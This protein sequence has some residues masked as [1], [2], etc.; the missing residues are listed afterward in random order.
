MTS[1]P[2]A[3]G[4]VC[5]GLVKA[6][7]GVTVLKAVDFA[8]RPGT[9]VGLIGENGAGKS[10]LSSLI[11]GVITPDAGTMTL[12]G[13]PYVP[14][15]PADALAQGVALI[16]QEVRLLPDLSVA[17]NI[18]LGRLP[19][20]NGRIDRQRMNDEAA[21]ALASLGVDI[22][23]RRPVR[24]LS[25]A[26]QQEIEIAKAISRHPRFVI[27]DEPSASLGES[28]TEHV[29]ARIRALRDHGA[30]VVYIS[31]RLGEVQQVAD[32]IV[33][34]RDGQRVSD[35]PKGTVPQDE[36]VSAMVGREFTLEH[37]DPKPSTD[38]VVL[39][40]RGLGRAGAFRDV[41]FTVA[42]GE[43]FGIAGL[44]GAGRTE[45]VRAIAGV[46][47]PDEGE[48]WLDGKQLPC[49]SPQSAIRA[50]IVM[51]PE[52]RK[53][54]GLHLDRSAGDNLTLPW[55]KD[56]LH[57]GML[58]SSVTRRIQQEQRARLDIRGDLS[59][60]V[61]SMSGGNQQKV[62]IGKWLIKTP[63][64][65]I[66]DEPTRGVD[67]GAKRAI[68]QILH[69]LAEQ[70]MAVIVVSSELEEVIGLSH[71]VLVMSQG[72]QRGILARDEA[73]PARV[74][75]LAVHSTAVPA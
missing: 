75:A 74:M 14:S 56:L 9:V 5:T 17:E 20:R 35:W 6:Y 7:S 8:V 40:V 3:E 33:C 59:Q 65:L 64:V 13:V 16:H 29:L 72:R 2:S 39:E 43:V 44:V 54:Q 19:Q 31:H 61:K 28:E 30:G 73:T 49:T 23:P 11:T 69:D 62:L 26:R 21:E 42:A 15:D 34:L 53:G 27:F 71:R 10:T 24:G 18:F 46:D 57:T 51:V 66:V 37:M 67:V 22:D 70:G 52:D 60:P 32:E 1:N 55:E 48:V 38:R 36:L 68:H 12:D 50:G 63:T 25:M 45:V 4:L 41:S 47:R 58:R